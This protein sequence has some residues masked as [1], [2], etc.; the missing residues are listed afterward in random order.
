MDNDQ[1]CLR[2]CAAVLL[3]A[4]LL[5]MGASGALMPAAEWVR[6]PS[7]ASFLW[8]LQTGRVIRAAAPELLVPPAAPI[9]QD[10]RQ[11]R[12]SPVLY[13]RPA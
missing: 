8:Y 3:S 1:R 9:R 13:H 5:R 6:S 2:L 12:R 11:T 4:V 7:A 10:R